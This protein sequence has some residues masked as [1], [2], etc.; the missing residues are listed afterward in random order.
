[1]EYASKEQFETALKELGELK[2]AAESRDAQIN[3]TIEKALA[4]VIAKTNGLGRTE[5][6]EPIPYVPETAADAMIEEFP[7]DKKAAIDNIVLLSKILKRDPRSLKSWRSFT[8]Q[9]GD[10][11]KSLDAS[12]SGEGSEWVPA[13]F[14]DRLFEK[15]HTQLKVMAL[16]PQIRIP[17]GTGTYTLPIEIGDL[18]TFVLPEQTASTGQTLSPDASGGGITDQIVLT[19]KMHTAKQLVTKQLQEDAIVPMMSFI[20]N[21]LV[22]AIARG[23]EDFALNGDTTGTHMDSDTTSATSKRKAFHG[24]RAIAKYGS[25]SFRQ[26]LSTFNLDNIRAMRKNLGIYGVDPSMLAIIVGLK[27]FFKLLTLPEVTTVD[28]M[29]PN[30]TILQGQLAAID[31]IPVIVSDR[32]REDLNTSGVYDGSTTTKTVMHIVY[33]DSQIIGRKR[34]VVVQLLTEKYAESFQDA[35]LVSERVAF[36]A[37]YPVASNVTTVM[38]YNFA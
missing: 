23:E 17:D 3:A 6:R 8:S 5:R 1:M 15:V 32:I 14:T 35:L 2:K 20:Q 9:M 26:D 21:R 30:A 10:F 22:R 36:R 11:K 4:D 12:T 27:G 37:T 16:F 18:D 13:D 38:G 28:K 24:L 7:S 34:D 33:R 31:G 25:A 29:G 19:S